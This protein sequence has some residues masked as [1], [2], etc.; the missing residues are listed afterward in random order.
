MYKK[1]E[2]SPML[3]SDCYKIFHYS[4]YD[5]KIGK[6]YSTWTPRKSRMEGIDK[7]VVFGLQGFIKKYLIDYFNENFFDKPLDEVVN[8]YR[9][10]LKYSLGVEEP[11]TKHIEDLHKLGYLPVKIDA[12][13][14]GTLC[15]IKC[16][17]FTIENTLPEFMWVT[18]FLET[19]LSTEIW[20]PMTSATIAL[21]YRKILDK[22]AEKTCDNNEHVDFQGHDF[23]LRGMASL[24]AGII[25]GA[26]HLTSFKG[27]DTIPAIC[28]LEQYYN[29]DVE[30]ECVGTS[31][32]A[33][34]HSIMEYNSYG[35]ETDEYEAF[36]RIITEVYPKGFVSIVSDTW[37]LWHV[38][39][40]TVPRLREEIARRDGRV[41]IRPDSGDPCDIICGL[42]TNDKYSVQDGDLYIQTDEIESDGPV[43]YYKS[44]KVTGDYVEQ[45]TK[46]VVEILWDIFGGTINSKGYKVLDPH[47]GAIYGDAITL[48]RAEEI[49]RRLESKGFA[50]SNIV[51]G[52]GSYTYN[53]NTR[54]TFGFALKT[55]HGVKDGK[56]I[57]LFKDPITDS[58]E[59]K[60]QKGMVIVT[61]DKD[62]NLVY[63]DELT[64]D[65]KQKMHSVD[66]LKPLFKDGKLLR[67]TSLSEIRNKIKEQTRTKELI[68]V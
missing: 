4:L 51:F 3:L 31:I 39:S 22:W 17:C 30:Q 63:V 7:V 61:H 43:S 28:Y 47:V 32:P 36:K 33:T 38:L 65:T 55:T 64:A 26:G 29:A 66:L 5:R 25:S 6:I 42:N 34:E 62:S 9:R 48:E 18:N 20:K 50:S 13:D 46:G 57:L 44:K 60:S 67:E 59:K 56:E 68:T 35:T 12:L 58:G 8:D 41:V 49:C 11:Y 19:L 53:M 15:P 21:Q 45:Q 52:I 54:D 27:T 40:D 10:I 1:Q 24:D 14:E 37:N 2:I 16:P 23:S